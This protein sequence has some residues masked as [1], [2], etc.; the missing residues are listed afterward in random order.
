MGETW[1]FSG[2]DP[3]DF[4]HWSQCDFHHQRHRWLCHEVFGGG[5]GCVETEIN[6]EC[7]KNTKKTSHDSIVNWKSTMFVLTFHLAHLQIRRASLIMRHEGVQIDL[8]Q[9]T[10]NHNA[11]DA[12]GF[13]FTNQRAKCK[14]WKKE[15]L[16]LAS[17]G[18]SMLEH[19]SRSVS[20]RSSKFH[21]WESE[22]FFLTGEVF[23]F[24]FA[25]HFFLPKNYEGLCQICQIADSPLW[26]IGTRNCGFTTKRICG[27]TLVGQRKV[28]WNLK[29]QKATGGLIVYKIVLRMLVLLMDHIF[30]FD[31]FLVAKVRPTFRRDCRVVIVVNV[32]TLVR[33]SWRSDISKEECPQR[34]SAS[35]KKQTFCHFQTKTIATVQY[36][37]IHFIYTCFPCRFKSTKSLR[38]THLDVLCASDA[39]W[40]HTKVWWNKSTCN[41]K[42]LKLKPCIN[43]G[44][45]QETMLGAQAKKVKD[46]STRFIG[47]NT[48][49]DPTKA[50]GDELRQR[51]LE[52]FGW[53]K[54]WA[55]G[56]FPGCFSVW[57]V[58]IEIL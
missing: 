38:M 20:P 49:T 42:W 45:E 47:K 14:L 43:R 15:I 17:H 36:I 10:Q 44:V 23:L 16:L 33:L 11:N 26:S 3:E 37:S 29:T 6:M 52:R 13:T 39:I 24:N 53:E 41:M 32:R 8:V 28:A 18:S 48:H 31:Q 22:D 1:S 2:E 35:T 25:F 12:N 7:N 27:R 30:L 58:L 40:F 56:A 46:T 34:D 19:P 57:K 50:T 51:R 9:K 54:K 5:D 21:C 4:G 55:N